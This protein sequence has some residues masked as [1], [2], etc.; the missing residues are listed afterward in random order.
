MQQLAAT[1][2]SMK[3]MFTSGN[4]WISVLE[5]VDGMK[6]QLFVLK[7]LFNQ[8]GQIKFSF[9]KNLILQN[10]NSVKDMLNRH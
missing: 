7:D 10:E 6:E 8:Q 5:E 1:H 4:N 3:A 2:A 9:Y